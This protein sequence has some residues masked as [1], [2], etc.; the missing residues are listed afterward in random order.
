M[1]P[2]N[3]GS[4]SHVS[5]IRDECGS[6]DSVFHSMSKADLAA[7]VT[8][9]LQLG[10]KTKIRPLTADSK[11]IIALHHFLNTKH[12]NTPLTDAGEKVVATKML[13]L[14]FKVGVSTS[15]LCV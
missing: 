2:L 15:P 5:S 3:A 8:Y 14:A 4:G 1:V 6:I 7:R 9:A 12:D 11:S 13:P 10:S